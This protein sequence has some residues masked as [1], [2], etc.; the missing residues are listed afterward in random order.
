MLEEKVKG[1]LA[2]A[3]TIAENSKCA[4]RK[5]GAV[6]TSQDRVIKSTG[7]NGSARGAL[8]CGKEIQCLKDLM[9]EPHYTSY[10][11]C[12]AVHAEENAIINAA[13]EG[14]SV[15]GCSL[16]LNSSYDGDCQSPCQRCRRTIINAGITDCYYLDEDKNIVHAEVASWVKTENEWMQEQLIKGKERK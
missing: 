2:V 8:N 14:T 3:R 9:D 15:K 11:Y 7:Y 6:I 10:N 13:R 5:F 1:F 4:R 12:P 16:F